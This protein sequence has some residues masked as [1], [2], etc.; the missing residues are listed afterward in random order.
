MSCQYY[1]G[2]FPGRVIKGKYW[3]WVP[4]TCR[5]ALTCLWRRSSYSLFLPA[6]PWEGFVTSG[7]N[8][9][10]VTLSS[11]IS[12]WSSVP[13]ALLHCGANKLANQRQ[14]LLR[15]PGMKLLQQ[16]EKSQDEWWPVHRVGRLPADHACEGKLQHSVS[17]QLLTVFI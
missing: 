3:R 7:C 10:F 8:S 16:S 6:Q 11:T 9:L 1:Y 17:Y 4:Q 12:D 5:G 2:K 13:C 14:E 15:V